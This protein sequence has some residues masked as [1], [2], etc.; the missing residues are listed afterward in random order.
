MDSLQE[1]FTLPKRPVT[2]RVN[3]H[4]ATKYEIEQELKKNNILYHD[5]IFPMGCLVLDTKHTEKDLWNLDIYKQGEI[6][7]QGISSQI[8]VW[9][10]FSENP[11]YILDACAAPGGK[12][13]QLSALYPKAK[14]YAFEPSKIRYDKLKYNLQKLGCNNVIAIHDSVQ[15]I[16]K[17]ITDREFFDMIL[18]DAPCSGE[19]SLNYY[20]TKFLDTWDISHIQKNYKRQKQICNSV[21]P[22][23]KSGWE[24]IYSTCTIAPEENEGVIHYILCNFPSL[25]LE[26]LYVPYTENISPINPLKKFERYSFKKEISENCLR[27]SPSK[28]SEWFFVGK[29]RKKEAH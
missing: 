10:F 26:P 21:I 28:M 20:N 11:Q 22:Y 19:W 12:T 7:I 16:E 23:L 13:S 15:N 4:I 25:T 18:V 9:F 29:L 24:F 1:I 3:T 5:V 27:I 6:Y 8:P 14:I 17:H 2:L